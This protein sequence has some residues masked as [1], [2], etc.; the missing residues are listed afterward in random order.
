MPYLN[1][2]DESLLQAQGPHS[3]YQQQL[4]LEL[5]SALLEEL[6]SALEEVYLR[7]G[8]ELRIAIKDQWLLFWKW[9]ESD[10]RILLAH[11]TEDE[12]V[13]TLA[14]N[15]DFGKAMLLALKNLKTGQSLSV[16]Q[17]G[18]LSTVTNLEVVITLRGP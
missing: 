9:R 16:S 15:P 18:P 10:S 12:W 1:W 11:P 14:L 17:V 5:T 3:Q 7:R 8:S 2:K 13:A 6:V 4:A